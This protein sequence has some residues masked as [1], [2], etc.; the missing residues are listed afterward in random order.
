MIFKKSDWNI[1]IEVEP[2]K[3]KILVIND[4]NLFFQYQ[5][6]LCNQNNG[7]S[8][9]F[10]LFGNEKLL[11]FEN[12]VEVIPNIYNL[13]INTRKNITYLHK[14]IVKEFAQ[15]N[16]IF[17][18]EKIKE[19]FNSLLI[20]L[21]RESFINFCYND[22]VEFDSFLKI[23]DI[24]FNEQITTPGELLNKYIDLLKEITKIKVVFI[25]FAFYLLSQEEINEL[26]KYCV[27][28][29]IALVFLEKEKPIE[30]PFVDYKSIYI[31]QSIQLLL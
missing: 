28:Y 9:T 12:E 14:K 10:T 23:Y 5:R 7:D 31:D 11:N 29:S 25:S 19:E 22:E 17:L 18:M 27:Q 24:K 20:N 6:E 16:Q 3:P 15:S 4:S 26:Y 8:G 2:D 13:T 1:Q 30:I 21:K